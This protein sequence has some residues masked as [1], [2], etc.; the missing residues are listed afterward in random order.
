MGFMSAPQRCLRDLG[1]RA[2][3]ANKSLKIGL[4]LALT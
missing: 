1:F 2:R 3:N 4:Q